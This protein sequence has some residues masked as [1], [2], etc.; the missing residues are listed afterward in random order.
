MSVRLPLPLRL[1]QREKQISFCGGGIREWLRPGING[2]LASEVGS[3][4]ALASA[5]ERAVSRPEHYEDLSKGSRVDAELFSA[6]RD[7]EHFASSN[8]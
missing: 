1:S 6:Q 4:N 8:S 5:I 7:V 3:S 2:E